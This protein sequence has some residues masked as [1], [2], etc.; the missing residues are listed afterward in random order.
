MISPVYSI[1]AGHI[2]RVVQRFGWAMSLHGSMQRDCDI[3]IT[4][5]TEDAEAD[6]DVVLTAIYNHVMRKKVKMH[7]LSK[8]LMPNGRIAYTLIFDIDFHYFDI[9]VIDCR[10]KPDGWEKIK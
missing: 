8:E 3:I 6:A 7:P 2:E 5:W 9:S 4:P 10:N 1:M